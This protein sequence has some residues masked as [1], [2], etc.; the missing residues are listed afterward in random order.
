MVMC[1]SRSNERARPRALIIF[2]LIFISTVSSAVVARGAEDGP[3]PVSLIKLE[4]PGNPP[5]I[6]M[7]YIRLQK[8]GAKRVN[9]PLLFDTG[10]S[11][12]TID[13]KVALPG[14]LC[15]SD[16]IRINRDIEIDDI[17]VT[18]E[19]ATAIYGGY[20]EYGNVAM[21]RL[22]FGDDARP[23]ETSEAIPI[24]IRYKK[25]RN[26]DGK[27]VGGPLWPLGTVGVSPIGGIGADQSIRSPIEAIPVNGNLRRGYRLDP[28]GPRWKVCTNERRDCPTTRALYIGLS[29]EE[30]KGY[31]LWKLARAHPTHNFP[32]LTACIAWEKSKICLPTLFDTGNST[33]RVGGRVPG[34]TRASLPKGTKVSVDIPG[35]D[36]WRFQLKYRPELELVGNIN[37][38][39]VGVRYFENNSL[40]VDLESDEIGLRFGE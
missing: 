3:I 38:H 26:S 19:K 10:S 32:T 27:I 22:S 20:T 2:V 16:G 30:K 5:N 17:L 28:I 15:S 25:V 39:I 33:I 31:H 9:Q 8:L 13:C 34:E 29:D 40:L 18:T 21:A 11:G 36:T 12:V 7:L 6:R 4:Y 14:R 1:H 23:A 37:H 24:L 35:S